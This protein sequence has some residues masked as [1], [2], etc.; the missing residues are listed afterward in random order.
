MRRNPRSRRP[1]DLHARHVPGALLLTAV[2]TLLTTS[3][4]FGQVEADPV[5]SGLVLR[6]GTP[7]GGVEVVLHRVD[8]VEAGALDTLTAEMDGTFRFGL[9]TV[10]DPGGRGEVYFASVDHQGVL[11][12][13]PPVATAVELDSTYRIEV[14]DT[15]SVPTGGAN[16]PVSVRYL[17]IEPFEAGWSVTDLIELDV[18]AG[19]TLV[20]ADS[21]AATWR[22]RMP[23]DIGEV[24]VGGGDIA[25]V[26]T[27]FEGDTVAVSMPLT[28]GLRQLVLRYAIDSLALAVPLSGETRELEVLVREPVPDMEVTGL[29]AVEP[30]ELEPGVIYRRYAAAALTDS[31]VSFQAT[32]TLGGEGVRL[33]LLMVLIGLGLAVVGVWAVRRSP[34]ASGAGATRASGGAGAVARGDTSHGPGS[35]AD[36]QTRQRI[37]LEIARLD[38]RIEAT[39]DASE[40]DRLAAERDELVARLQSG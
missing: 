10:P 38:E 27:S 3:P 25:P 19:R 23:A 13:G 36:P 30:V 5:L 20:P 28:P 35:P 9:P 26:S 33:D 12:F 8:A 24:Q 22:Y 16:I 17:L 14:F 37:L 40:R 11:Y 15:L 21:G 2:A 18:P 1:V 32:E 7:L 39:S 4:I 31:V 6:A 29:V 34:A